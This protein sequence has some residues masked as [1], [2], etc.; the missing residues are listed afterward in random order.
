VS[1]HELVNIPPEPPL[2]SYQQHPK[3][4]ADDRLTAKLVGKINL[5]FGAMMFITFLVV[6]LVVGVR[7]RSEVVFA[8]PALWGALMFLSGIA[9]LRQRF[10]F[11][12]L[13]VAGFTLIGFPV[14]TTL[15]GYTI[16]VLC[17]PG[18][19]QLY[20]EKALGSAVNT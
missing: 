16:Y 6:D 7:Q 10:W 1:Q 12:S 9:I 18:V 2:L 20:T 15:G 3:V 14:G 11:F 19:R 4:S 13:L 17:W 8:L 5:V